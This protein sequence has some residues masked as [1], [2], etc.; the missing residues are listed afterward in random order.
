MSK[1]KEFIRRDLT[2]DGFKNELQQIYPHYE[3]LDTYIDQNTEISIRCI[4]HNI[5]FA[6][7]QL[8]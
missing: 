8:Q 5:I 6:M 4:K 3:V 7:T 2:G 1:K